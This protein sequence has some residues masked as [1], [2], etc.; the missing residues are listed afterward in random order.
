MKKGLFLKLAVLALSL[1]T[2]RAVAM[3]ANSLICRDVAVPC[4]TD[5]GWGECGYEYGQ[6]YQT[7]YGDDGSIL[8]NSPDC[9]L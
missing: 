7:C 4:S 6:D 5:T 3:P 2:L 1:A 8:A 9:A